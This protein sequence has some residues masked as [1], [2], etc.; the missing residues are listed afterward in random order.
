ME[1]KYIIDTNIIIYVSKEQLSAQNV[2]INK[3]EFIFRNSFNIS[4]MTEIELL[5]CRS[6]DEEN[7]TKLK[8]FISLSNK[9]A[10]NDEIKS[11][12]IEIK[13]KTSLKTPDAIIAATALNNDFVL[14]TRNIKD[15]KK[16]SELNLFNPFYE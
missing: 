10:F 12:T 14:V 5:D 4:F 13:R 3:L 11:K 16:L 9:F 15:F 7:Y 8:K 2:D 1:H 6:L